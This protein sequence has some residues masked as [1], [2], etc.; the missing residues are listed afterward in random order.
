MMEKLT[1]QGH[2]HSFICQKQYKD[3]QVPAVFLGIK[4]ISKYIFP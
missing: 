4:F 3:Q 2:M 1:L